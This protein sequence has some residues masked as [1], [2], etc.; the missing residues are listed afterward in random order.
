ME[1]TISFN[2]T[3]YP[4]TQQRLKSFGIFIFFLLFLTVMPHELF[5][6]ETL[7]YDIPKGWFESPEPLERWLGQDPTVYL[8]NGQHSIGITQYG[9][10][11]SRFKAPDD[12]VRWVKDIFKEVDSERSLQVAGKAGTLIKLHY[13]YEGHMDHHG[14]MAPPQYVYEEFLVLPAEEGF[15]ALIFSFR[16]IGPGYLK[17][18]EDQDIKARKKDLHEILRAW[19]RFL[20]TC[21]LTNLS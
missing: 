10:K 9:L 12:F 6:S 14:A 11:N 1:K 7:K 16:Q 20:K 2:K 15:W 17:K 13:E 5:A 3:L 18:F 4:S 19:A 21:Q 8:K